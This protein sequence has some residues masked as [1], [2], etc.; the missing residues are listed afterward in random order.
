MT[1]HRELRHAF[2]TLAKSPGFT[3]IAVLT[4]ALGIGANTA[5][6]SIVNGVLLSP[7][8]YPEPDRIVMLGTHWKQTGRITP[9]LTGGD[10]LDIRTSGQIFDAVSYHVGGEMGVQ[11]A[12]RAEFTGAYFVNPEFFAVFGVQPSYG[13]VFDSETQAAVS[14]SFAQRNFGDPASA[15]GR[16]LS[17]ENRT[18]QIAGVL[19]AGF[20][21]PGRANVWVPAPVKPDNLNRTSYNYRTVA[22]LKRDV[23]LEAAEAALATIGTRLASAYPSSNRDKSFT[24][25]PLRDQLVGP[26][27]TM[28]YLLMG[29][30]ALVL[31]IACTNVADLMLARAT[32]R[33]REMSVRA[34][35]GAGRWQIVRPLL[36]ESLVLALLGGALGLIFAYF[37]TGALVRMSATQVPLPRLNEIHVDWLV[38]AFVSGVSLLASLLFGLTPAWQA[39]RVD[40][41]DALKQGGSRGATGSRSPHLRN[42]LV[43]AQIAMSLVLAIGAGLLLRSFAALNSVALGYRTEG[44]LV[45]Y[46]HDPAR[47]LD[48]YIGVGR[49]FENIFT[50]IGEIPG[51]TGVSAAMGLPSG[52]YGSNGG[53]AVEG[54]QTF[55]PGQRLPQSDFTLSGPGYFAA[56]GIPLSHGRD[57]TPLDEYGKLPVAIISEALA[58]QSFPNEDPIGKRLQCGLDSVGVWMTIIGVVGDV[59]QDSPALVPGPNLYMPLKQHPYRGNE[60][61]VV[62]RAS[63]D[64]GSLTA[65]IR[66]RV[67]AVN[68]EIAMKFTTMKTMVSDSIAQPRFRT[69]LISGFAGLALVLAMVGV[70]GVMSYVITQRTSEFGLRVA[71]GARPADVVGLV[72][73]RTLRLAGVGLAIGLALSLALSRVMTTMV[74]GLK[75]TDAVTY[76]LVLLAVTPVILAASAIPAWRATRIDPLA[77]LREE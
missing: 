11:I 35:L 15:L 76:A 25:V 44:I 17:I 20:D 49:Q 2:R 31:L 34:A 3:I 12:G 50:R 46:A 66:E 60:V 28:L 74:F 61:Q 40:L 77:A 19:P 7:L 13:H 57:F 56:M 6:F 39:S 73:G 21:F 63:V 32:A 53:Y 14:F 29:A 59:R 48:Q 36:V 67:R 33:S 27:R 8:R 26:V 37:G 24:A 54:K 45:M 41:N 52:Q 70:Y 69:L 16:T 51:V 62:V 64:P 71:L 72:L 30:V 38:L 23:T 43:V 9:R 68:P 18:Y 58:R 75:T 10:L 22:R 47:S 4:L 5:I 55:A 42:A 65:P 1:L